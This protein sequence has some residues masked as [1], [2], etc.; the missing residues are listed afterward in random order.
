MLQFWISLLVFLASHSVIS[1][2]KLRPLLIRRLGEKNYFRFYSLLSMVLLGWVFAAA[3]AAPRIPLWPWVHAYYWVPNITMPL[4]C[5]FFMSGFLRPNP[6]SIMAGSG[7]FNPARPPFMIAVTRHPV[8]WG[9]FLWAASHILPNGE[10]PLAFLFTVFALFALAGT[11]LVDRKRRRQLGA[12]QWAQLAANTANIP[13]TGKGLWRGRFTLNS[14][15]LATMGAG[16]GLYIVLY[17]LHPLLFN[18]MPAPPL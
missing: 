15:D 11:W 6:L 16:L 12:E 14:H 5:I 18:I 13:L 1:R 8:L 10:F 9:F 2:T 4:A 7:R 3:L 17:M